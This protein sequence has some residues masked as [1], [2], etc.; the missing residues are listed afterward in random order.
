MNHLQIQTL[1]DQGN[2]ARSWHS[3]PLT[4]SVC[5][6]VCLE[7]CSGSQDQGSHAGAQSTLQYL[8]SIFERHGEMGWELKGTQHG[9]KQFKAR[10][11]N[12]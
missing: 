9:S 6:C 1:R 12:T 3:F 11:N 8:P 4:L 10:L 5:L 2:T 7:G